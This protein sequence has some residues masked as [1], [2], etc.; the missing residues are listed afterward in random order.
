[1][2]TVLQDIKSLSAGPRWPDAGPLQLHSEK[3]TLIWS[4]NPSVSIT[5]LYCNVPPIR[6]LSLFLQ[7][8]ISRSILLLL[9]EGAILFSSYNECQLEAGLAVENT[10]KTDPSL[11]IG[12]GSRQT[13]VLNPSTIQNAVGAGKGANKCIRK[14]KKML[15]RRWHLNFDFPERSSF[16]RWKEE[17]AFQVGEQQKQRELHECEKPRT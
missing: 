7:H 8:P 16:A 3:R 1:M 15:Q 6:K 17:N 14:S 9:G 5:R 13:T 2:K 11:P 10:L 4:M 12:A